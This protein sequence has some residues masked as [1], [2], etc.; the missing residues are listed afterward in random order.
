MRSAQIIN[1]LQKGKMEGKEFI[2]WTR[3]ENDFSDYE[4]L[5]NFLKSAGRNYEIENYELLN[6]DEMWEVLRRWKPTGLRRSKS[7]KS[8]SIEWH[9]RNKDGQDQT[10]TCPYN[11]HNIMSIFDTETRGKTVG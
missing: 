9:H 3:K 8:D 1:D 11:A 5:E 2:K 10:Y 6:K 4:L 7:T